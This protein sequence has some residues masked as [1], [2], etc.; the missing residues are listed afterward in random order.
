VANTPRET[1]SGRKGVNTPKRVSPTAGAVERASARI[2]P[3]A[4]TAGASSKKKKK[5]KQGRGVGA[6]TPPPIRGTAATRARAPETPAKPASVV[7]P[8][9]VQAGASKTVG[10]KAAKLKGVAGTGVPS[11]NQ[12]PEKSE[13]KKRP[14]MRRCPPRTAAIRLTMVS[15][16][17]AAP[18]KYAEA[19][20]KAREEIPDYKVFGIKRMK[21]RRMATGRL[22]LEIPGA[23]SAQQADALASCLREVF[24]EESGVKITRPMRRVELR[25]SQ[26]EDSV[27]PW[28]IVEEIFKF[29]LV[30][31]RILGSGR[32]VRPGM[33]YAQFGCRPR[34]PSGCPFRRREDWTWGGA[35]LGRSCSRADRSDALDA[36]PRATYSSGVPVLLTGPVAVSTAANRIMSWRCVATSR[37]ARH[38]RRDAAGLIISSVA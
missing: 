13:G 20:Q 38:T 35:G 16:G 4:E 2:A 25:L 27:T 6:E 8:T 3:M 12:P 5:K 37:T 14:A 31:R 1:A 26:I 10:K 18:P 24:P 7:C 28:L 36:W 32:F 11:V 17:S 22:L 30:R 33:A 34:R 15:V 29:G 9:E 23:A 21:P 19:M